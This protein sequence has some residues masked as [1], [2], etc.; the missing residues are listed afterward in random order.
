MD[1][2]SYNRWYD[3]SRRTRRHVPGHRH[4]LRALAR[5]TLESQAERAPQHHR[6]ILKSVPY[7]ALRARN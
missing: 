3:Y 4:Q 2:K 6:D 5:G 7:K 1:L